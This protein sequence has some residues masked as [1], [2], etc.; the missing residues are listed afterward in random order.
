MA[1]FLFL[2]LEYWFSGYHSFRSFDGAGTNLGVDHNYKQGEYCLTLIIEVNC[3]HGLSIL[4]GTGGG[5]GGP[6]PPPTNFQVVKMFPHDLGLNLYFFFLSLFLSMMISLTSLNW[7]WSKLWIGL[8]PTSV[9]IFFCGRMQEGRGML[10]G[11]SQNVGQ[12]LRLLLASP[13]SCCQAERS[14]SALRRVKTWLRNT[15]K[16]EGELNHVMLCQVHRERLAHVKARDVA[17]SLLHLFKTQ[18]VENAILGRIKWNFHHIFQAYTC[19]LRKDDIKRQ[20]CR[21]LC[22]LH[23]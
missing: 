7:G 12:F 6:R 3:A 13:A 21:E 19:Y 5:G 14:F 1:L 18:K 8:P 20:I 2:W 22:V 17:A 9:Q 4:G 23:F 11:C 16:Q 10:G 15:M